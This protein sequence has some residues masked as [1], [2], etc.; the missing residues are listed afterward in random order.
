MMM[1]RKADFTAAGP[2]LGIKSPDPK[3]AFPPQV[4]TRSRCFLRVI[5]TS[6]ASKRRGN[7]FI[8]KNICFLFEK[9]PGISMEF[10]F[11]HVV[12]CDFLNFSTGCLL[13]T[14]LVR[15][16]MFNETAAGSGLAQR[17]L[18]KEAQTQSN[19]DHHP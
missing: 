4:C 9:F 8:K 11:S 16:A 12:F 13:K 18:E 7:F 10:H 5:P 2:I 3:P 17:N 19:E 1:G 15:N 6:E 14:W